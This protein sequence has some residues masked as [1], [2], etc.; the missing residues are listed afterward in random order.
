MEEYKWLP[1]ACAPDIFP[2]KLLTGRFGFQQGDPV[3]IPK[4]NVYNNGWGEIGF[5]NLTENDLHAA[6]S[7]MEV[8]WFS[9]AENKFYKDRFDLAEYNI[10]RLLSSEIIS[11]ADGSK[12]KYDF[13]ITGFAPGG[14]VCLWA[15]GQG[16]V[17]E[18][19][20]LKARETKIE[21]KEIMSEDVFTQDDFRNQKL[22]ALLTEEQ[23]SE[24]NTN[25]IQKAWAKRFHSRYNWNPLFIGEV[26]PV[27]VRIQTFNGEREFLLF[28]NEF[29]NVPSAR[30]I[31]RILIY[32]WFDASGIHWAGYVYF[33]AEEI[34]EMFEKLNQFQ[35]ESLYRLQIQIDSENNNMKLF[36][37]SDK[38]YYEFKKC[39][40]KIYYESAA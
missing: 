16:L 25:G 6:P 1:V 21:W 8:C 3:M 29:K 24:L 10:N 34:M 22:K 11:P 9:L 39:I 32:R 5:A 13:L 38:F 14:F 28:N 35:N 12:A 7:W 20:L 31:P 19:C 33:N 17:K 36:L 18:I 40:C 27:N 26:E 30:G 37:A 4:G 2:A 15:A 23:L